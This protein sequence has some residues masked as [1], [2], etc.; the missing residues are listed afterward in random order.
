[1]IASTHERILQCV[2]KHLLTIMHMCKTGLKTIWTHEDFSV[3]YV[4]W[5]LEDQKLWYFPS[6]F[7]HFC[8]FSLRVV[9]SSDLSHSNQYVQS[10]AL[11]TLACMGSAEMCRDLAP[12]ID[13]LLRASNSYI[14]KKVVVVVFSVLHISLLV[15]CLKQLL[16][17]DFNPL[18]AVELTGS[19][20]VIYS[21]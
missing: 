5:L 2:T 17:T 6:K 3:V 7:L 11:C 21:V 15:A 4:G 12:E 18:S 20:T 9:F 10:L 1:M 16:H 13:R 8:V 14:K 19:H